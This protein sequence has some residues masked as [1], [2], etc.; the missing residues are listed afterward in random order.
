M[1]RSLK[2]REGGAG[3]RKTNVNAKA[4]AKPFETARANLEF[5]NLV[6]HPRERVR[7]DHRPRRGVIE[8]RL[9]YRDVLS[10]ERELPSLQN[11]HGD[12]VDPRRD[13]ADAAAVRGAAEDAVR[14]SPERDARRHL[15]RKR[16]LPR[17][18]PQPR[19][20]PPSQRV[21]R[22]DLVL[23]RVRGDDDVL[24]AAVVGYPGID[25]LEKLHRRREWR[26]HPERA[27]AELDDDAPQRRLQGPDLEVL[28]QG[29]HLPRDDR[30]QDGRARVVAVEGREERR[31][32]LR[33]RA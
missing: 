3:G 5:R 27:V 6:R 19:V 12:L 7:D 22:E 25:E 14:L 33:V 4:K 18:D 16:K 28:L 10:R 15:H 23:E 29:V 21:F 13:V 11:P 1:R 26:V 9:A 32:R 31:R 24:D 8:R 30:L 2:P 17:G 20:R